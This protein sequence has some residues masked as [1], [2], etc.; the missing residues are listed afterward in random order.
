LP[1]VAAKPALFLITAQRSGQ[2]SV[3]IDDSVFDAAKRGG[4]D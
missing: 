4:L 3:A 1:V 2:V